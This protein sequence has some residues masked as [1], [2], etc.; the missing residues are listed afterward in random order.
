MTDLRCTVVTGGEEN[1]FVTYAQALVQQ[2][3]HMVDVSLVYSHDDVE[4]CDIVFYLSYYSIVPEEVL[5]LARNNIVVHESD[6][7]RGRGWSPL[8][9]QVLEGHNQITLSLIEATSRV[10]S[11][12]I[13]IQTVLNF[14]GT[15]LINEMRDQTGLTKVSMCQQFVENYPDIVESG[16]PQTGSVTNYPRRTASDSR[17][18]PEETI[19]KQFNLLRIVD[20]DR[21]PAFF[22]LLGRRY[23]LRIDAA[24]TKDA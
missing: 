24:D 8:T 13:Y 7:P 19:A 10:D 17:L 14:E 22:D 4:S 2:L 23:E 11:G 15:E 12:L 6:L 3:E 1:W 16:F 21:Y 9:W 20:N 18:D 5:S